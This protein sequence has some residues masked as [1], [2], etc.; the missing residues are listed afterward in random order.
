MD[1][2]DILENSSLWYP[3]ELKKVAISP[4]TIGLEYICLTSDLCMSRMTGAM[5][6][7][8]STFVPENN[9]FT[10]HKI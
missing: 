1:L 7:K 10:K 2:M 4:Y 8:L 5:S 6:S 9:E 3:F